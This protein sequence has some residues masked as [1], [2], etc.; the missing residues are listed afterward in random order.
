[1]KWSIGSVEN[2][3]IGLTSTTLK[4]L[5]KLYILKQANTICFPSSLNRTWNPVFD[6]SL[7]LRLLLGTRS[8]VF[9]LTKT[10]SSV[11]ADPP[12][13]ITSHRAAFR[14]SRWRPMTWSETFGCAKPD[15][16]PMTDP[17]RLKRLR[18]E[19]LSLSSPSS[20][21]SL[22]SSLSE[23]LFSFRDDERPKSVWSNIPVSV[24]KIYVPVM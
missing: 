19:S 22:S 11:R 18:S 1:M 7:R 5:E 24:L 23:S 6:L 9:T 13:F 21:S 8:I 4:C 15:G 10:S 12:I 14:I 3:K 17:P 2:L 16:N 20:S